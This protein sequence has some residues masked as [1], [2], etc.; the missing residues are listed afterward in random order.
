LKFV[1]GEVSAVV[2]NDAVGHPVSISDGL[3]ELDSR[4]CF[5]IGYRD[6]FDPLGELV[7]GD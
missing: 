6:C 3:E 4:S 7:N 1:K 5:L 2:G